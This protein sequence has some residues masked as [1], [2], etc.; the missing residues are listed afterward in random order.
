MGKLENLLKSLI[1]T[2]LGKLLIKCKRIE[3]RVFLQELL[4]ESWKNTKECLKAS[5][6]DSNT[7]PGRI[8]EDTI[9]EAPVGA[10]KRISR[11]FSGRIFN[12]MR[13]KILL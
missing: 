7:N 6:N 9:G 3:S 5:W 4:K 11:E 8:P 13:Y 12:L 10:S 1:E 2:F